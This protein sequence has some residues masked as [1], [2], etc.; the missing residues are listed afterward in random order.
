MGLCFLKDKTAQLD[1]LA[2]KFILDGSEPEKAINPILECR[3]GDV[4]SKTEGK[5][6]GLEGQ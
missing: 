3:V 4:I 2:T 1:I 5:S 6:E